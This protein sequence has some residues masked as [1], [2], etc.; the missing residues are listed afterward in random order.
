MTSS[1][2]HRTSAYHEDLRWRIVWLKEAL[3]LNHHEVAKN[4]GVD[5]STVQRTLK[6]FKTTGKI[7]KRTY[8]KER[9]ARK[10]TLPAQLL[11]L[12]LLIQKPTMYLH[13]IQ[14]ELE[15]TLL[16]HVSVPAICRYLHQCGFSRQKVHRVALQRDEL[17]RNT[18]VQD[19]TVFSEDMFVFVDESGADRRNLLRQYGY[20]VRGKTP[21]RCDMLIRGKRVSTIACMLYAGLLDVKTVKGTSDGDEFYTFVQT[22]LLPHLQPYNGINSHSVVILDNCT[23]HHVNEVVK[24]VEDVGAL[25]I[26]L[27][28]Y[29]PDYNPIE[30]LFSKV[31][32]TLRGLETN[33]GIEDL[34]TLILSSFAEITQED[35]QGYIAMNESDS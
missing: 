23:I 25:L 24:S 15:T 21:V 31:K 30:E 35:C 5:K 11:I 33:T 2:A 9:C 32:Y 16:L 20:S 3:G 18:F 28:P 12:H 7:S 27:P 8:P 34:E 22:H 1:E 13:E 17:L 14:K 26:F 10:L 29:S 4:L 6:I 19:M